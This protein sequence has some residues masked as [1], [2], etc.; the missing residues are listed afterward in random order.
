MDINW[1]NLFFV[2]LGWF[3]L[4]S[5]LTTLGV[6]LFLHRSQTHKAVVFHG[7]VSHFFRFWLWLTTGM[8]TKEWIGVHRWHHA[9]PDEGDDPHSPV[10]FGLNSVVFGGWRLYRRAIKDREAIDHFSRGYGPQDWLEKNFYEKFSLFG[11]LFL[12][13]AQASIGWF[14]AGQAGV[15]AAS[16]L[17]L[18]QMIWIPFWAAGVING[19]GHSQ[20]LSSWWGYTSYNQN[21]SSVNRGGIVNIILCGE[22]LHEN[23][24][25]RP[26]SAK[27]SHARGEFD[28]GWAYIV[29]LERL[30]LVREIRR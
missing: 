3:I 11:I 29:A 7:A 2:A 25:Q 16:F 23:H 4:T 14:L 27:F 8:V 22:P 6:T 26:S 18:F 28:L 5:H 15:W 21:N 10:I 30:G 9:H 13:L 1:R 19:Y 17:W 24:H 20:G 12:L